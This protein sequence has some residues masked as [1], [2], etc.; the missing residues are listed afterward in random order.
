M[1][2]GLAGLVAF[3]GGAI[4]PDYASTFMETLQTNPFRIV[5]WSAFDFWGIS[6][7][8]IQIIVAIRLRWDFKI[9]QLMVVS[10]AFLALYGIYGLFTLLRF[11]GASELLL[12][13]LLLA[14]GISLV[15]FA[16]SVQHR[17]DSEVER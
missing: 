6:I 8:I 7:G 9:L 3:L 11:D 16:F 17:G 4:E 12:G 5:Y 14:S 15:A 1:I 2:S 13:I 10:G